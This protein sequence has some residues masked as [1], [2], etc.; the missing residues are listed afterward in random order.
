MRTNLIAVL[1]PLGLLAGCGGGDANSDSASVSAAL[2]SS[3]QTANESALLMAATTGT[4]SASSSNEAAAMAGAGAKTNWQPSTC[5]TATQNQNVVSYALNNC[6]GPYG[7]V[8][9]T[10]TVVATYSADSSGIH[11][12]LVTNNLMVNGATMTLNSSADYSVV[13]PQKSLTVHTSGSGTGGFGN[14]ITRTGSFTL[15]WNDASQCGT[16]DGAW[17]TG[18]DNNTWSTS[19]SNYAQ[20]KDRCPTSGTLAHTGGLSHVTWTVTFDGSA[21]AKWASSRGTSGKFGL[22][23]FP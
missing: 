11:A 22:L 18:L 10:G 14:T 15:T 1:L 23:C 19:I 16:I 7:L 2:D 12:A 5:V 17:S 21:Q 8:H 3:G 6:T 20:C 4:E 9:V 13:G